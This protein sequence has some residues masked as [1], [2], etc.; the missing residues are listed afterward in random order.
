[1]KAEI[2]TVSLSV[3]APTERLTENIPTH[4][5][6]M[7]IM[8]DRPTFF[9]TAQKTTPAITASISAGSAYSC[10][11][12][13]GSGDI[14]ASLPARFVIRSPTAPAPL[15]NRYPGSPPVK[16]STPYE[17]NRNTSASGMNIRF[18]SGETADISR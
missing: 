2:F 3:T 12:K 13:T 5:A 15:L 4:A 6:K 7:T 9:L 16:I 8:T 10:P 1:M 11:R 18:E 17:R 14:R